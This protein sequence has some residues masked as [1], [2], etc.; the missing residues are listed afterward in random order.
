[1][2]LE[3]DDPKLIDTVGQVLDSGEVVIMPCDTI[4]GFIGVAPDTEAKI[5]ELKGR[6]EKSFLRLIPDV[7]WL[8]RYTDS[9]LPAQ[10]K[11]YWPGALTIIFPA[12]RAGTV[13]L[14]IPDD[15]LLMQL[16]NRLGRPLFSTSVNASGKPALW[17]IDDILCAFGSRVALVVTAGDRPQGIP[18]T[19]LDIT[20]RPFRLLRRG[21]VEISDQ[22]LQA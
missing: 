2:K 18:S 19:I 3:I 9:K 5:R 4:Y 10:L 1:V 7:G 11:A 20:E 17:R 22:L 8:P 21:V 13:A 16:M 14:R 6:Q 12:K 15:P